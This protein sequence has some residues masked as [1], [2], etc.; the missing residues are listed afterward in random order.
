MAEPEK[1]DKATATRTLLELGLYEW[2]KRTA[3]DLLQE[4]KVSFTKTTQ[5]MKRSVW[6]L[7]NLIKQT[8]AKWRNDTAEELAKEFTG[9]ERVRMC[10]ND[11]EIRHRP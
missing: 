4:Q 7:A 9:V 6:E 5:R 11:K 10:L 8:N 3:L 1:L 2:K